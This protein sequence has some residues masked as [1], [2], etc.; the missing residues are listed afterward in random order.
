MRGVGT[1]VDLR[2]V[3][4]TARPRLRA[5]WLSLVALT[6]LVGLI[7]AIVL[8]A[9]SASRRAGTSFD[10]L[11]D[12][13]ASA[14]VEAE[15]FGDVDPSVVEQI[16]RLDGVEGASLMAFVALIPQG[17]GLPFAD[18]ITFATLVDSG[19]T[20]YDGFVVKGRALDPDA[21]DEVLLNPAMAEQLRL[22]VGDQLQLDAD[23]AR[24]E[25]AELASVIHAM[26]PMLPEAV[27]RPSDDLRSRIIDGIDVQAAGLVAFALVVGVVGLF[28]VA[29]TVSRTVATARR[30]D[31]VLAALGVTHLE[32]QLAAVVHVLPVAVGG[33]LLA[34]A[35][36]FLLAPQAI[37]GL[38]AQAEPYQ[39]A[40]FDPAVT[41]GVVAVL[42]VVVIGAA[43]RASVSSVRPTAPPR[44]GTT[45]RAVLAVRVPLF[46]GL[47]ARRAVGAGARRWAGRA[48]TGAAVVAIAG[49]TAVATFDESIEHL[50]RSPADWGAPFDVFVANGPNPAEAIEDVA[51]GL[52][53]QP[54]VQSAAVVSEVPA[55]VRRRDGVPLSAAVMHADPAVGVLEPWTV[56]D[57]T[58]LQADTD[59]L[60]GRGLLEDLGLEVGSPFTVTIDGGEHTLHVV[61]AVVAYGQ[62]RVDRRIIVTPGGAALL[63]AVSEDPGIVV[64]LVDGADVDRE[65]ERLSDALF[66]VERVAPPAAIDNL[67]ELGLLPTALALTVGALGV[68]AVGHALTTSVSRSRR[69]VA[70][71]RALGTT[72][73]QLRR[74]VV[75]HGVTVGGIGLVLGVPLGVALGRVAYVDAAEGVGALARPAVPAVALVTLA[76]VAMLAVLVIAIWPGHRIAH[77]PPGPSLRDE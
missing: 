25:E 20:A 60:V 7:G 21:E 75:A 57:G 65:I 28:A 14:T 64:R 44:L 9:A 77:L 18:G 55:T 11:M 31:H 2:A 30:E 40:W 23:E 4:L 47:G 62:E 45:E 27:V 3:W 1:G 34:A 76:V 12:A 33:S 49:I 13:A 54:A 69:E 35:V 48:A 22:D 46:A 15:V 17:E 68:T 72:G 8:A 50:F 71:L 26:E 66:R 19:T 59:A 74:T 43:V 10:R 29:Q 39:G 37:T 51:A 42:V 32:R 6:L 73:P 70:S 53:D 5:Q 36:G 38:A 16:G 24:A 58:D 61:G 52:V 67:D 63:G 41:L 56:V